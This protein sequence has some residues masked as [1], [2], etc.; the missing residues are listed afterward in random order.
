MAVAECIWQA[1]I[2]KK[3]KR[4][5]KFNILLPKVY[6]AY[7]SVTNT[8]TATLLL[9]VTDSWHSD[10]VSVNEESVNEEEQI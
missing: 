9:F 4:E 10:R 7:A 6:Y 8:V 3:Q 1:D 5:K 2:I